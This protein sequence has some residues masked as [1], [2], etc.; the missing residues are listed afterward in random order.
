MRRL[1]QVLAIL[2]RPTYRGQALATELRDQIR[3]NM[4]R[5]PSAADPTTGAAGDLI[6]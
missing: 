4:A 6:P 2:D 5:R 3:S 1:T